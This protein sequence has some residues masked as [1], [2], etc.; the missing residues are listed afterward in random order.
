MVQSYN[1]TTNDYNVENVYHFIDTPGYSGYPLITALK[2]QKCPYHQNLL[3]THSPSTA[4][5]KFT[6]FWL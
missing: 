5:T 4:L 6:P 1:S 2:K 3:H